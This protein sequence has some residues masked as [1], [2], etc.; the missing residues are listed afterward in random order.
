MTVPALKCI[1]S[2]P[3]S[4]Q[5]R[6]IPLHIDPC[7]PNG[8]LFLTS[9]VVM[10]VNTLTVRISH[11]CTQIRCSINVAQGAKRRPTCA[12]VLLAML[13]QPGVILAVG[14]TL[15]DFAHVLDSACAALERA[16]YS[17]YF[18]DTHILV[19]TLL[20]LTVETKI[21][22]HSFMGSKFLKWLVLE[23]FVTVL[24]SWKVLYHH[25]HH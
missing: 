5:Q 12:A 10:M 25:C 15:I 14:K 6:K 4:L 11:T 21:G 13:W 23:M 19:W 1:P 24:H 22:R 18:Y 16:S 7:R 9:T 20:L 3:T 8:C 17:I 2:A